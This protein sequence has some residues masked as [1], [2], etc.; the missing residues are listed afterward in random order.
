MKYQIFS[1][2]YLDGNT[3]A[4]DMGIG[5]WCNFNDASGLYTT[6][7]ELHFVIDTPNFLNNSSI[8]GGLNI[9]NEMCGSAPIQAG[10]NTQ[11]QGPA[12]GLPVN[13]PVGKGRFAIGAVDL[14]FY[15]DQGGD[16]GPVDWLD[17]FRSIGYRGNGSGATVSKLPGQVVPSTDYY[18][19]IVAANTQL[20]VGSGDEGGRV[21]WNV[22]IGTLGQ[23]TSKILGIKIGEVGGAG[24]IG[25]VI[26]STP[27]ELAAGVLL[28]SGYGILKNDNLAFA[29]VP[30]P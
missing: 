24:S 20:G 25:T 7:Q 1:G 28:L 2:L 11:I 9:D 6:D 5:L 18:N 27:D 10:T 4:T 17:N 29:N 21:H 23:F 15:T 26:P 13:F 16:L 14:P 12:N 30:Q 19:V 8:G 22:N 3:F